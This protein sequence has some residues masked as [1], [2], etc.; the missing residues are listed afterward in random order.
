MQDCAV[1]HG[2]GR[3]AEIETCGCQLCRVAL[4]NCHQISHLQ[5][6]IISVTRLCR[7]DTD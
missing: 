5:R 6:V 1:V 3:L 4:P 2:E 7:D